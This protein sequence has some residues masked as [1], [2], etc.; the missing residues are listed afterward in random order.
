M[1]SNWKAN[2]DSGNKGLSTTGSDLSVESFWYGLA[3]AAS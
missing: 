3:F 2:L 1:K